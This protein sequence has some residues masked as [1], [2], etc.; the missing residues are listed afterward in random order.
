MFDDKL[1]YHAD[2]EEKGIFSQIT[3]WVPK[4]KMLGKNLSLKC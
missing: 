1:F 2:G 3:S 4:T